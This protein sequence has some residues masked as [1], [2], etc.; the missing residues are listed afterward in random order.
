MTK[1]LILGNL[2]LAETA[3]ALRGGRRVTVRIDGGS[4]F[5]FIRG[6]RD[7]VELVP[8]PPAGPLQ[9]WCCYLYH[10][11]GQ[12]MIHRF[13]GM[14]GDHCLFMGDGNVVRHERVERAEVVGLLRYIVRPDGRRVDCL[15]PAWL[16]RGRWWYRWR[17]TRRF[18][19]PLL[20]KLRMKN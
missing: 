10:W 20:F 16:R 6:G 1:R 11:E 14:D 3:E 13:V 17:W 2:F 18:L 5:P 15:S 19:Y 12:Y 9:P 8:C 7:V 4:M